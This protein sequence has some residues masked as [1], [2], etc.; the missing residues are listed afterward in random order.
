M[1]QCSNAKRAKIT[2]EPQDSAF[3]NERII[4][5]K[6]QAKTQYISLQKANYTK[7]PIPESEDLGTLQWNWKLTKIIRENHSSPIFEVRFN[8]NSNML[9]TASASQ[10]NI[11][12]N[13]NFGH[14]LD[15]VSHYSLPREQDLDYGNI[16]TFGWRPIEQ[17]VEILVQTSHNWLITISMADS[18]VLA[19]EQNK[20]PLNIESFKGKRDFEYDLQNHR[21]PPHVA[22]HSKG[23]LVCVVG[24]KK[25]VGK[26]ITCAAIS[27]DMNTVLV[28]T[29]DACIF[30][31]TLQPFESIQ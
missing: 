15:L 4:L 20:E 17:N 7:I 2:P 24:H 16:C 21:Q 26:R 6:R 29:S 3:P 18:C 25:L 5:S 12:D 8:E 28:C 14:H 19:C 13:E 27:Q 30:R 23:K 11:Y 31:F 9:A 22:I 1:Q 10:I